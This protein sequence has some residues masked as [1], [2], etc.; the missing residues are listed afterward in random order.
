[1]TAL[2]LIEALGCAVLLAGCFGGDR[3]DEGTGRGSETATPFCFFVRHTHGTGSEEVLLVPSAP[4]RNEARHDMTAMG[5]QNALNASAQWTTDT[6]AAYVVLVTPGGER[7][8]DASPMQVTGA[9]VPK[10]DYAL[11]FR[12]DDGALGLSY[13]FD[14]D[15]SGTTPDGVDGCKVTADAGQAAG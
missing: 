8:F 2:R 14:L 12:S 5:T 10:G 3:I 4:A 9:D 1:V 11:V 15:V 7:R 13:V 6:G